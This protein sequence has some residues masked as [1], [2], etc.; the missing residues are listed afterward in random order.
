MED[1]AVK[2]AYSMWFLAIADRMVWPPSLLCDRKWPRLTKYTHSRAVCQT[3]EG[4]LVKQYI[5]LESFRVAKV[6][7]CYTTTIHGVQNLWRL[8]TRS[9]TRSE[10][11]CC[12]HSE[13]RWTCSVVPSLTARVLWE[14]AGGPVALQLDDWLLLSRR[15]TLSSHREIRRVFRSHTTTGQTQD[16]S[17]Q[18]VCS[19]EL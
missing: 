12:M 10:N 6:Q 3:L 18:K 4:D 17:T 9:G 19:L 11:E 15:A 13:S 14:A 2:F 16:P 8:T 7:H 5:T 1:R